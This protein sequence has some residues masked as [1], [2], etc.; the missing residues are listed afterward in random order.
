MKKI[1]RKQFKQTLIIISKPQ[2]K[3]NNKNIILIL[4]K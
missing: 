1:V 2:N 3:I 4:C